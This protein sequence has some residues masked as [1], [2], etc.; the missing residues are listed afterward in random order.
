MQSGS[1][2]ALLVALLAGAV[3]ATAQQPPVE[4]RDLTKATRRIP[5]NS[6]AGSAPQAASII[7]GLAMASN[8]NPLP[9]AT[10]HLRNLETKQIEQRSVTNH[11]GEF[12]FVV[13]PNIPYVV[14]I[15]GQEGQ[16][17]AASDV[18]TTQLGDVAGAMVT[19]PAPLPSMAGMFRDTAS[20]VLSAVTGT[21]MTAID[22]SLAPVVSPEQ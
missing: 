20:A 14:E 12:V 10:V 6:I 17:F 22:P 11:L 7:N 19:L 3:T 21:G 16:I 18:I 2:F 4:T 13:K 8:N 5:L 9:N 1:K 15:A